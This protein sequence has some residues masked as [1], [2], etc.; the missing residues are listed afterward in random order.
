[1]REFIRASYM[2]STPSGDI[3]RAHHVC[4]G[5]VSAG[6]AGKN[7]LGAAVCFRHIS[8]LRAGS[9]CVSWIDS[10]ERN[11]GTLGLVSDLC[12][13]VKETPVV[14]P[15][16]IGF[17]G[18]NVRADVRQ[19]FNGDAQM[20]A[21]SFLNNGF[22]NGVV[23]DLLESGLLSAHGVKF[24]PCAAATGLLEHGALGSVP[25]AHSLNM[26]TT[27]CLPQAV[28]GNLHDTE[29]YTENSVRSNLFVLVNFDN[30]GNVPFPLD[31]HQVYFALAEWN[32]FALELS[33]NERNYLPTSDRPEIDVIAFCETKDSIIERLR[34]PLSELAHL[35]SLVLQL[36]GVSNLGNTTHSS[37]RGKVE[38]LAHGAVMRLVQSVLAEHARLERKFR[39]PIAR[40]IAALKRI[41]KRSLLRGIGC[42]FEVNH[43]LHV[44]IMEGMH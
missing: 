33:T 44:S 32:K 1:M 39:K 24:A 41:P 17:I 26:L 13:E 34:G 7:I 9:G 22:G 28:R 5:A 38:L 36:V 19:I 20:Q 4:I 29:V 10:T 18:L 12:L 27:E 37:L 40:C 23:G 35:L 25:L 8:A 14:E 21:F 42:Q 31:K 43:K 15:V 2:L 3:D 6:L 30:T 11:A 16:A